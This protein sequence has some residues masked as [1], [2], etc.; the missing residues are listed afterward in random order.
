MRATIALLFI[1]CACALPTATILI[2]GDAGVGKSTLINNLMD[3]PVA[4]TCSDETCTNR[5]NRYEV[6]KYGILFKFYDTPGF[7]DMQGRQSADIMAE[8]RRNIQHINIVLICYDLSAPRLY[9]NTIYADLKREFGKDVSRYTL[10]TYT[11]S[12]LVAADPATKAVKWNNI[13]HPDLPMHLADDGAA[14]GLWMKIVH[15]GRSASFDTRA[16]TR[17]IAQAASRND[18][19]FDVDD[20]V[21]Q[22]RDGRHI[23]KKILDVAPGDWIMGKDGYT[24]VSFVYQH[25]E[26]MRVVSIIAGDMS[27]SMTPSHVAIYERGDM[28]FYGRA[29]DVAIGDHLIGDVGNRYMV[30]DSTS[31]F[32][33]VKYIL[34]EDDHVMV[35]GILVSAHVGDHLIGQQITA[36]FKPIAHLFPRWAIEILR[37][38]YLAYMHLFA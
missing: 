27:V 1:A 21:M 26:Q 9:R 2:V 17:A 8:I 31:H 38:A 23:M 22:L 6:S 32:G 7:N 28:C 34:T 36:P 33:K 24:R 37:S 35:N 19:C 11:K 20:T 25:R 3:M 13:L 30:T 14:L 18:G 16:K 10:A 5:V 4:K 29:E 15:S 12:N